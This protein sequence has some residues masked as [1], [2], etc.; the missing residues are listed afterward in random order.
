MGCWRRMLGEGSA[1]RLGM[2]G[3]CHCKILPVLL[4]VEIL[5]LETPRKL[6]ER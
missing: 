5:E 6:L 4:G 1:R 3:W 2:Q